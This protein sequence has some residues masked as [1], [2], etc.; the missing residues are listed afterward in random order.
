MNKPQEMR[1]PYAAPKL[2]QLGDV[3][4]L[5]QGITRNPPGGSGPVTI[6]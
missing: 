1:K 2:T 6:A 3:K 5:T 4:V